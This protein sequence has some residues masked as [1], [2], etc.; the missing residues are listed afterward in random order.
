MDLA[1]NSVNNF[2]SVV[3]PGALDGSSGGIDLFKDHMSNS[4]NKLRQK[5]VNHT[6]VFNFRKGLLSSCLSDSSSTRSFIFCAFYWAL[7]SW[8]S[9]DDIKMSV[10]V[11]ENYY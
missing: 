3:T 11:L 9:N 4:I 7:N 2:I 8:E 5:N 1:Q 6:T 10:D